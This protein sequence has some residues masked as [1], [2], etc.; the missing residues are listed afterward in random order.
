MK[1]KVRTQV[2]TF[3]VLKFETKV[4]G[5]SSGSYKNDKLFVLLKLYQ[6]EISISPIGRNDISHLPA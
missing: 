3:F 1:K 5:I 6:I 2:R 4:S